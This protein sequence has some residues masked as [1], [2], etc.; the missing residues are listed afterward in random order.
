MPHKT[1]HR[2]DADHTINKNEKQHPGREA[3][4]KQAAGWMTENTPVEQ[5]VQEE[6]AQT[7]ADDDDKSVEDV[8]PTITKKDIQTINAS[9]Q[10]SPST[11]AKQACHPHA[12]TMDDP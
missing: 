3:Q 1:P 8:T 6:T 10:G 4:V 5:A 2:N 7:E 12:F 11:T 9:S